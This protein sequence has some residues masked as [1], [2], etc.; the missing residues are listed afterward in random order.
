MCSPTIP[1]LRTCLH[2]SKIVQP[3]KNAREK[4]DH[5]PHQPHETPKKGTTL[6]NTSQHDC[7]QKNRITLNTVTPFSARTLRLQQP[8]FHLLSPSIIST[9]V[10][11]FSAWSTER[12]PL[13]RSRDKS[14]K[15][16][17]LSRQKPHSRHLSCGG[18]GGGRGDKSEYDHVS[19]AVTLPSLPLST[20]SSPLPSLHLQRIVTF[21]GVL[22]QCVVF[23][24]FFRHHSSLFPFADRPLPLLSGFHGGE[25]HKRKTRLDAFLVMFQDA[26]LPT[27]P[28][29]TLISKFPLPSRECSGTGKFPVPSRPIASRR[30][31]GNREKSRPAH[32][33]C[34]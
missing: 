27:Y 17:Y 16:S 33:K 11:F 4:T 7:Q 5:K 30:Y 22:P 26:D 20:K 32:T 3:P 21:A 9:A 23:H 18:A 6:R 1:L 15:G 29:S 12:T 34:W 14:M 8:H 13:P 25:Y 24:Q 10:K 19:L 31:C 2:S 28:V